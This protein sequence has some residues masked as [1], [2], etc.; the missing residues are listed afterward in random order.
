MLRIEK[1]S[2]KHEGCYFVTVHNG[3]D[4]EE[5]K[6]ERGFLDVRADRADDEV[7]GRSTVWKWRTV[8]P[9]LCTLGVCA[10]VVVVVLMMGRRKWT[11]RKEGDGLIN[12]PLPV[13]V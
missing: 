4:D 8:A 10:V 3:V 5:V 12:S 9:F 2:V 1:A 13:H 6:E 7:T 11:C